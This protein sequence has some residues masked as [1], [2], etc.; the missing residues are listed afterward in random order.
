MN[1]TTTE[2]TDTSTQKDNGQT[3]TTH[4]TDVNG[5]ATEKTDQVQ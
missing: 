1:K 4:E 3:E 2:T 5:K